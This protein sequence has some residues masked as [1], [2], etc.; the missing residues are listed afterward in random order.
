MQ[1]RRTVTAAATTA[2]LALGVLAGT[3]H[4]GDNHQPATPPLAKTTSSAAYSNWWDGQTRE[5]SYKYKLRT[6]P[7]N[8]AHVKGTLPGGI[9]VKILKHNKKT[10]W[11]QVQLTSKAGKLKKGTTGYIHWANGDTWICLDDPTPC[12]A[13]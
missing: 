5:T 11:D 8:T 12:T 1:F 9:T 3:A 2:V 4:A 10:H 6:K 13:W 7:S